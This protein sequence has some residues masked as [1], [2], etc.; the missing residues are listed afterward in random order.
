MRGDWLAWAPLGAAGLHI[1]E[2]FL[3]PGGFTSWSRQSRPGIQTSVTP[4]F[5]LV[6]NALLLILCYDAGAM[7][8]RSWGVFLW[9]VVAGLLSANAVWH[10]VGTVRTRQ[11]SPG[12]GTGLLLYIPLTIYGLA[13]FIG[14]SRISPPGAGLALAVGSSYQFWANLLHRYR[15]RRMTGP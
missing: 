6:V 2:E 1:V 12:L 13:R 15:A 11:Y 8:E 7:F 4:R 14:S 9:V 10:L 3:Y 5:L